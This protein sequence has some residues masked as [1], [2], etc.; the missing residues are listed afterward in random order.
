MGASVTFVAFRAAIWFE[1]RP[2]V[3]QGPIFHIHRIRF[4]S[5]VHKLFNK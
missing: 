2:R 4:A 1:R 5:Q 3:L